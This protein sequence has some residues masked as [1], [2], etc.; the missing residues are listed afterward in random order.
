MMETNFIFVETMCLLCSTGFNATNSMTNL[1]D[2]CR[3]DWF[4]GKE[5]RKYI[6]ELRELESRN[7]IKDSEHSLMCDL[8]TLVEIA[9][10]RRCQT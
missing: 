5:V 8:E 1:C 10:M 9:E 7:Q 2:S 3:R 4:V 6:S